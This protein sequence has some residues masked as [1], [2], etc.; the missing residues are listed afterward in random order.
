MGQASRQRVRQTVSHLCPDRVPID[1][2]STGL[3][4]MHASLVAALRQ[5]YGLTNRPPVILEPFTMIGAIESDLRE[6][7]GVDTV[8]IFPLNN[9]FGFPNENYKSYVFN[10]LE[11][12]VPSRFATTV[13]ADGSTL[14]YPQGDLTAT[15][16][17][18]MHKG[19][20]FFDQIPRQHH[21]DESNLDPKDNLEEFNAIT[22]AELQ[23]FRRAAQSAVRT[24]RSVVITLPGTSFGCSSL[25]PGAGLRD[26][27]GIRD[28]VE[29]MVSTKTRKSFIH[30]VFA[31]QTEI[32]L[33]NLPKI[34]EAVGDSVDVALVDT[35]DF[36]AQL[37][38]LFSVGTYSEL[39]APY[40]AQIN[41]WIHANTAWKTMKH[42]CGYSEPFIEGFLEAGFDIFN[43]VQ[44]SSGMD[45]ALLKSRYRKRVVFWGGGVETQTLAMG[46]PL[47][48]RKEVLRRCRIFSADGGF[49]FGCTHNIQPLTPVENVVAMLE[50]V[51][52]FN[53]GL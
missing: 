5:Y 16:S 26:P 47:D 42:S 39:F 4:G 11:V 53:N 34:Y 38:P 32:A 14:L 52:D 35:N 29:W 22:E 25:L 3:T 2:G 31:R 24:G 50:A 6:Q 21:F 30:A 46:T 1:F 8:G 17:G 51:R 37:R 20:F 15:P 48:V 49:V 33:Q 43:P 44:C 9:V 28:I 41:G 19:G 27:R 7:M 10:G 36:G 18:V 40:H 13:N 12:L 45:P 23:H